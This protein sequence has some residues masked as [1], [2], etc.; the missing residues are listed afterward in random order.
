MIVISI[1]IQRPNTSTLSGMNGRPTITIMQEFITL[2]DYNSSKP[3]QECDILEIL[4]VRSPLKAA[5]RSGP[6]RN[7]WLSYLPECIV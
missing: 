7:E 3:Q 4:E 2:I 1:I 5:R 6:R